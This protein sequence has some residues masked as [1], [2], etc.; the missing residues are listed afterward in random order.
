MEDAL[1][2][3]LDDYSSSSKPSLTYSPTCPCSPVPCHRVVL[4]EKANSI[5][6]SLPLN[7]SETVNHKQ[8]GFKYQK[9]HATVYVTS[10]RLIVH[11]KNNQTK[12]LAFPFFSLLRV[13]TISPKTT[14]VCGISYIFEFKDCKTL[15]LGAYEPSAACTYFISTVEKLIN[16]FN[17]LNFILKGIGGKKG[18]KIYNIYEEFKR[19]KLQQKWKVCC[20]NDTYEICPSYPSHVIVPLDIHK[21]TLKGSAEFRTNARFPVLTWMHPV[22]RNPLLR[23]SQP[24]TGINGRSDADVLLLF[25][26]AKKSY[27]E[28][29]DCRDYFSALGNMAFKKAG[30][31][32]ANDYTFTNINFLNIPNIHCVR[33]SYNQVYELCMSNRQFMPGLYQTKWLDYIQIIIKSS[34]AITKSLMSKSV[35]V[36]CSDGWDRTSQVCSIVE[37]LLDPYYRTIH[38]FA[39]LIEK[40]WLAFGHQFQLRTGITHD[41]DN[42]S[43]IMFQ[44]LHCVHVILKQQPNA[45]EF[46]DKMLQM[47][48]DELNSLRYGTFAF[49]CERDR[50]KSNATSKTTSIWDDIIGEESYINNNYNSKEEPLCIATEMICISAWTEYFLRHTHPS[51][52]SLS[53]Y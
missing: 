43:P 9:S 42:T 37:L 29:F 1:Q 23:S 32:S 45:F 31:E 3:S 50:K 2:F 16:I 30:F 36:H 47:I 19:L 17:P 7:P 44:F 40:D 8:K 10:H 14:D 28:I 48:A 11:Y 5:H 41:V 18:W 38:G 22:S 52:S 4:M 12:I 33:D 26:E 15:T 27:V 39:V 13:K 51:I 6:P 35:L 25:T 34:I 53:L 24:R 49:N 21:A 46:N 20:Y